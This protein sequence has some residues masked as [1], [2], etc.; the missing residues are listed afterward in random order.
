MGFSFDP[1]L[2]TLRDHA[3]L[4]LGDTSQASPLLDDA[5]IDAKL[6]A[7]GYLEALAQ[8]SEA[9]V[10]VVSQDP[11]T[12]REGS[13]GMELDWTGRLEGWKQL[14][15]DARAGRVMV[16]GGL[17]RAGVVIDQLSVDAEGLRSD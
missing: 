8:C 1:G 5:T 10:A 7:F 13:A 2:G 6:R 17:V 14:A 15:R 3:R 4:A 9:C 11:T 16:P 12:Y